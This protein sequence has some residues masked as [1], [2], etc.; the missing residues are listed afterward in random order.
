MG[1]NRSSPTGL[2]TPEAAERLSARIGSLPLGIQK[3]ILGAAMVVSGR[4]AHDDSYTWHNHH[5]AAGD[6]AMG[7]FFPLSQAEFEDALE[8]CNRALTDGT[9][10]P[11][12]IRQLR[13][14]IRELRQ[15]RRHLSPIW[16]IM[17]VDHRSQ[18]ASRKAEVA[19]GAEALKASARGEAFDYGVALGAAA[20]LRYDRFQRL[21]EESRKGSR[22]SFKKRTALSMRDSPTGLI[23]PQVADAICERI[24]TLPPSV[25]IPIL[26]ASI[27]ASGDLYFHAMTGYGDSVT[28]THGRTQYFSV[29]SRKQVHA[30][31]ATC[32]R[33]LQDVNVAQKSRTEAE[34]MRDNITQL[35]QS[36]QLEP[37]WAITDWGDKPGEKPKVERQA[38]KAKALALALK[39]SASNDSR[40]YGAAR[41][42]AWSLDAAGRDAAE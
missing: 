10:S 20:H 27:R 29:L 34:R 1:V 32:E 25:Q 30:A 8:R 23:S 5:V 18:E 15:L 16:K 39:A 13:G 17:D 24:R 31:L 11:Q 28:D 42:V 33:V 36:R 22:T 7:S 9:R 4:L 3:A 14:A 40:L 12:S 41:T 37:L 6:E 21:T 26:H 2:V 38:L 35:F 19:L